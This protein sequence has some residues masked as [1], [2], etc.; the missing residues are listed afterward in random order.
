[1]FFKS[2]NLAIN[3]QDKK[4]LSAWNLAIAFGLMLMQPYQFGRQGNF[5]GSGKNTLVKVPIPHNK[6][7]VI[8]LDDEDSP[9]SK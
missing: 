9:L 1:V 4:T 7:H 3:Q 6:R 5:L 2:R 8:P